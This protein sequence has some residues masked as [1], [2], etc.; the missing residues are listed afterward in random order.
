MIG[1]LTVAKLRA[2]ENLAEVLDQ[3][4]IE[5]SGNSVHV[6]AVVTKEMVD[7]YF[8]GKLGVD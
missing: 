3:V 6:T 1:T 5:H 2:D 7:A 8:K 4:N